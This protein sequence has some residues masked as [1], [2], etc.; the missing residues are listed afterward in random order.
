MARRV[1]AAAGRAR[2]GDHLHGGLRRWDG[3]RRGRR[4][5]GGDVG[6]VACAEEVQDGASYW[7]RTIAIA[8]VGR[9]GKQLEIM[10]RQPQVLGPFLARCIFEPG[11][12]TRVG[13]VAYDP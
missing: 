13:P 12:A 1:R 8:L 11:A 9:S 4:G 10:T 2:R 6:L 7:K 3:G 5:A